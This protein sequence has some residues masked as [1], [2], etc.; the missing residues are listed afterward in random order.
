MNDEE[1]NSV[2]LDIIKTEG[3]N[4]SSEVKTIKD[5]PFSF[6]ITKFGASFCI[7]NVPNVSKLYL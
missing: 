1:E 4:E 2:M 6:L 3:G 5:Y 7:E